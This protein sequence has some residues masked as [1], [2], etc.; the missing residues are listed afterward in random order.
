M[1]RKSIE[2]ATLAAINALSHDEARATLRRCCGSTWWCERVAAQLPLDSGE[3][4]Q[5]AVDAAFNA[6]PREAWLEAFASHPRIG[7][8]D[9][10]KMRFAGNREW[11]AGEQA[12]AAT[13]QDDTLHQLARGN[14]AYEDRFGYLFIVCATGKSAPQMLTLLESRLGNPPDEELPIAAAQQREIT[15]L[16]LAKLEVPLPRD[17]A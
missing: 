17:T 7:D 13:A 16:R 5:S 15:Q 4:F 9:S 2:P 3:A 10:L 11:S 1:N 8:F 12:G 6:M 14:K